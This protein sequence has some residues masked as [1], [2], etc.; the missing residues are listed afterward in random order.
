M[1]YPWPFN[2]VFAALSQLAA[3]VDTVSRKID[4]VLAKETQMANELQTLT[5]QVAAN[6]SAEASAIVLLQGLKTALDAA[7][8]ANNP[9]ALLDLSNQLGASQQALAAAIVANTPAAPAAPAKKP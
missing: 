8:A 4:L 5:T 9:Q 2:D 3:R 7:I 1:W 6:T